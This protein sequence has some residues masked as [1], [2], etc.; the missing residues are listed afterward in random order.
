M[1]TIQASLLSKPPLPFLT[2]NHSSFSLHHLSFNPTR[3][4]PR[5]PSTP[6]LC[7]FRP[8]T[9]SSPSEP[10]SIEPDFDSVDPEAINSTDNDGAVTVSDSN[11]SR[12]EAVG[13]ESSE[14]VA[15]GGVDSEGEKKG[16][17]LV[18]GDGRLPIV[19]FL[20]GLWAR[21]KE[22]FERAFSELFGWWP[23]WRQEKRLA[24][25]MAEADG[26]LQ[27]AAKQSALFVELNKH[28]FVLKVLA[29]ELEIGSLVTL[30]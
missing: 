20:V 8:D 15:Q 29:V 18:V 30:L 12:F 14:T 22:G 23:F 16:P 21:A 9:V 10:G 7:T 3:L 28:R 19:V 17:D 13:V 25:L 4:R 5:V 2:P 26:N 1:A 6:L 27:D 11:E 24:R